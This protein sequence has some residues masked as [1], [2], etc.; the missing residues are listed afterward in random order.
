MK[1]WKRSSSK[2]DFLPGSSRET[3]MTVSGIDH[4]NGRGPRLVALPQTRQKFIHLSE[5]AVTSDLFED[6]NQW[7]PLV[8]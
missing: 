7:Y 3:V 4:D 2:P 5:T 6:E 8:I 1:L